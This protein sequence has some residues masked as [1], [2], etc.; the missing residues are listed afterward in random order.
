[1]DIPQIPVVSRKRAPRHGAALIIALALVLAF[2][3]IVAS[4]QL[5]VTQQ[6]R[7]TRYERDYDRALQMAEAGMNAYL[8]RLVNGAGTGANAGLVPSP[9]AWPADF[10]LSLQQ[11]KTRTASG[12]FTV[13]RYPAGSQQGYAVRE[14]AASNAAFVN[15]VAYGWSNGVVRRVRVGAMNFNLFDWAAIWG[16]NNGTTNQDYAWKFSG[17]AKVIG[18]CGGEGAMVVS[19]NVTPPEIYYGPLIWARNS[20]AIFNNPLLPVYICAE[21]VPQYHSLIPAHSHGRV[22]PFHRILVRGLD[23]PTADESANA[24]SGTTQGVNFYQNTNDNATGFRMLARNTTTGVI[25]QLPTNGTWSIPTTGN[26]A[27]VLNWPSP[28]DWTA[29][30]MDSST[31][32]NYGFRVY[33]GHYYLQ[34][35]TMT[36]GDRMLVRSFTDA[37]R[38]DPAITRSIMVQGDPANPNSGNAGNKDVRFWIGR[39]SSGNDPG[40]S[41]DVGTEMEYPRY[42][43]RFRVYS[44]SRSTVSIQGRNLS[45]SPLPQFR[46]NLLAYNRDSSGNGYGGVAFTSS[47]YLFGSLISWKVDVSG[48]TIIEKEATEGGGSTDRLTYVVTDWTELP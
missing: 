4:T 10:D 39:R 38:S 37:E 2:T 18:G 3:M 13:T 17:N 48:G 34:G 14:T 27:Y 31:E 7:Q 47:V 33:P 20:Y 32:E 42:A 5:V 6:L 11:F 41:F 16:L 24:Y 44:A 35:I 46:V 43:S 15:L 25:R 22:N 23:F 30:G 40:V 26:S 36:N 19:Q 8:N 21:G 45:S 12:E 9:A 29:A 1:M 28:S